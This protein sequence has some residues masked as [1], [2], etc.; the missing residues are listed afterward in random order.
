VILPG[1]ISSFGQ[2]SQLLL[3]FLLYLHHSVLSYL[4]KGFSD[5]DH[6]GE[7]IR[8]LAPETLFYVRYQGLG[9]IRLSATLNRICM[10]S[11]VIRQA[12][13]EPAPS[14]ENGLSSAM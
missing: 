10:D 5:H 2:V 14:Y 8:P 1:L 13:D 3:I 7:R 11:V 6:R 4:K 12:F 9:M